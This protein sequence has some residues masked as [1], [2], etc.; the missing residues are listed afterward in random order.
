MSL[1]PKYEA[2]A[3]D[4]RGAWFTARAGGGQV[5]GMS[6]ARLDDSGGCRVD[7]FVHKRFLDRW[8]D[9][10]KAA[11]EWCLDRGA[12]RVRSLVAVEDEEKRS[13]F[14]SL[15]FRAAGPGEDFQLGERAVPSVWLER[16]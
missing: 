15:G 3:K 4:G 14:E 6:T 13:L 1:Y 10:L 11:V 2:I 16:A 8:A 7:G 9:L 12:T 5:V